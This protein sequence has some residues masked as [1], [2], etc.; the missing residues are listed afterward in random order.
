[1]AYF[2]IKKTDFLMGYAYIKR[3]LQAEWYCDIV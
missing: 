2:I 1:M 3:M